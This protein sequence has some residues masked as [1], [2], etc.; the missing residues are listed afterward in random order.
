MLLKKVP[1]QG[2]RG[3]GKPGR[4]LGDVASVALVGDAKASALTWIT[5]KSDHSF[6]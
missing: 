6:E 4:V 3:P 1:R 5:T 2:E